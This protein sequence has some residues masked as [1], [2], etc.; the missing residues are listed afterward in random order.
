MQISKIGYAPNFQK[1]SF[2]DE[3]LFNSSKDI[4][5][6]N[7]DDD[8]LPIGL[9]DDNIDDDYSGFD[10]FSIYSKNSGNLYRSNSQNFIKDTEIVIDDDLYRASTLQ[11]K[12]DKRFS[13]TLY[14]HI[15]KLH[16]DK[17]Y[18]Y[19][20]LAEICDN[21]KLKRADNSEYMDFEFL[22]AAMFVYR[23]FKRE[24]DLQSINNLLNELKEKDENGNEVFFEVGFDCLKNALTPKKHKNCD[25]YT[26]MLR[27]SKIYDEDDLAIDI[28]DEKIQ[29]ELEENS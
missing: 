22:D 21:I 3:E 26:D 29:Y 4:S 24:N 5:T 15:K 18:S 2:R 13:G 6:Q 17:N 19:S 23:K 16:D 1:S 9:Q 20:D 14:N 12:H 28:D 11:G 25:Y 7:Y 10:G 27:N 8:D